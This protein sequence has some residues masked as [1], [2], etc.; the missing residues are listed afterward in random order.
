MKNL[1][2]DIKKRRKKKENGNI[3]SFVDRMKIIKRISE[4][5]Q[6]TARGNVQKYEANP[7]RQED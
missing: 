2:I 7:C 6:G 5:K 1:N 4:L 3:V